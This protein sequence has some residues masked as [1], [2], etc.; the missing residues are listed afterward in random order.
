MLTIISI[1]FAGLLVLVGALLVLSPGRPAPFVDE[2]GNP[3][4]GS[5]SEKIH[6]NINGVEQGMFI[7]SK[8]ET[9]PVLLFLHGGPGMPEYFLTQNYPTGLEEHFTVCWWEQ[10]GSG[11]S[12][13]PGLAAETMTVEQLVADTLEVTKTLRSRF[14]KEKIYLMGHSGGS[15]IGIQAAARAP[16]LYHAYI[17]MAQMA[18]QLKSERLAYEYMIEQ[19]TEKGNTKMVRKLE[20]APPTMTVPLPASYDLLRDEAMH[21][22]GI[23]TTREM[24]SVVSGVF[25]PSWLSREYTLGE[26]VNI[27]RGKISSKRIL[28]NQMLATDLTQQVTELDLPVYFFHGSYDY[29]VTYSE[30]KSYFEN[31]KAPLKGFY[32]FEQS[33]HTPLFEEPEKMLKILREDVLAGT[34]SLADAK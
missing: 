20:A 9:N 23:G 8:D 10:R 29:T 1:L 30:T 28:W 19:Y 15:F 2:N 18:Y 26:K 25:L 17:G 7:K 6:V 12:Y 24:K 4:A 22:L 13:S 21:T 16:E 31:L 33:A 27:W 34:N 3:L 11:L 14:G 5:I 32:T